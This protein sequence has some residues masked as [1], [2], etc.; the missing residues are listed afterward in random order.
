MKRRHRAT[1]QR[2]VR[3]DLKPGPHLEQ[4]EFGGEPISIA[5]RRL[6]QLRD[7][8]GEVPASPGRAGPSTRANLRC[9]PVAVIDSNLDGQLAD[10]PPADRVR[11]RRE[12]TKGTGGV[13]TAISEP[14][15]EHHRNTWSRVLA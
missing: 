14:V 2:S 6:G 13:G 15:T 1:A 9:P 4:P 5:A 10:H 3:R 12:L 7:G 8:C 11:R